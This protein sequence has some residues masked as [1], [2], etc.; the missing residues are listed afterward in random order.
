MKAVEAWK[1]PPIAKV[2]EALGA[3]GDGR[4]RIEDE[5]RATVVS[6]DGSKTYAVESAAEGREI[7][8]NDNASF[9]QGY[10]GY[11]AIAVM[12]AR[13]LYRPKPEVIRALSGVP[14]K[15]LNTQYRNDY[16]RTLAE[17]MRRAEAN[18]FDADAIRTEAEAVLEAVRTAA[19]LRGDRRR[20]PQRGGG[21]RGVIGPG[22]PR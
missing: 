2:Y 15:Q 20:P 18:G 3:I 1:M 16:E 11:P 13:G 22:R 4:V 5:R 14:W 8:S 12:I 10:L 17:V 19:P 21:A 9:W 7:S 6:S